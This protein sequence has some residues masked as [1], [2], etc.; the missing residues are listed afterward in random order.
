MGREGLDESEGK[1]GLERLVLIDGNA[2][3]HRAY[4]A[5]PPLTTRSGELVNAVYGF[6]SM[7]LKILADLKP[8]YLAVAF[9]T[10]KP[11]FRQQ[12]FVGYQ[13]KRKKMDTE[14]SGQIEKVHE[15]VR[16]FNI[17]IYEV[18]GFEADDVIG[19]LAKQVIE[20]KDNRGNKEDRGIEVLIVTGDRDLMQLVNDKVKLFMPTRGLSEAET[21]GEKEVEERM[22]VPPKMIVDYKSLVGDQS[23]G[24]P[25]VPGIGP[26][27][28]IQLLEKYSSLEETYRRIGEIGGIREI[29]GETTVRKLAEGKESA[30]LSKRLAKIVTEVPISLDLEKCLARDFDKEKVIGFLKEMGFRSL[31]KRVEGDKG[32]GEDKG[33]KGKDER[34]QSL[35]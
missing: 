30:E 33:N 5:L 9:D 15:L 18:E 27:R 17:P 32:D 29:G 20:G 14:L 21:V 3:L 23:D 31:V 1:G 12:E 34:Q 35:F 6:S 8:Q 13:A 24:Y 2:I 16:T 11:T 7:L 19:T 4:H 25:G 26:K 10:P 22:G 28:A